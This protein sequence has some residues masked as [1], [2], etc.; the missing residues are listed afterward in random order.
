[1][2]LVKVSATR[3]LKVH[4]EDKTGREETPCNLEDTVNL[5]DLVRHN[6]LKIEFITT[7]CLCEIVC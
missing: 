2:V 5:I 7:V 3:R 1:M 4:Q 6:N